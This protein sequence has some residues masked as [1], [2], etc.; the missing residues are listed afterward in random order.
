M[1]VVRKR[2]NMTPA[3]KEAKDLRGPKHPLPRVARKQADS[4]PMV[5][6][7]DVEICLYQVCM[8]MLE[9]TRVSDD[10]YTWT[11]DAAAAAEEV[12]ARVWNWAREAGCKGVVLAVGST[13]NWRKALCETYKSN[14]DGKKKPLGYRK[15]Q[16]TLR[17]WFQV[18]EIRNLEADDVLGILATTPQDEGGYAGNCVIVSSDK[19]MRTV[20]GLHYNP[21]SGGGVV[22]ISETE[23]RFEHAV[24]ALAGDV[25][26]GYKGCPGVGEKTAR[27]K[28][29]AAL[30]PAAEWR[31]AVG[32]FAK[33]GLTEDDAVEQFRLARVLQ[34]GDYDAKSGVVTLWKPPGEEVKRRRLVRR[35]S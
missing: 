33:A 34:R 14:R 22:E 24:R 2:E 5:A 3:E 25:A 29:A 4:K 12:K 35:K 15:T 32:L 16:E 13:S 30:G 19:D 23:A 26:D 20:P 17:A 31:V 28:L 1:P 9:E 6:L 10:E 21:S 7:V 18:N 11:L 8:E 27:A